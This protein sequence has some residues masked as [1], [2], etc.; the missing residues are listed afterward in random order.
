MRA[1]NCVKSTRKEASIDYYCN[2]PYSFVFGSSFL[3]EPGE[4]YNLTYLYPTLLILQP[5]LVLG[6]KRK[7]EVKDAMLSN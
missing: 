7:T 4:G 2:L 1:F 6:P 3:G 5:D